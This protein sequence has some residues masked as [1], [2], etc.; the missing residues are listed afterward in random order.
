[1]RS[2]R[3]GATHV[4]ENEDAAS[5]VLLLPA[6]AFLLRL[7]CQHEIVDPVAKRA[8]VASALRRKTPCARCSQ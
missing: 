6:P 3:R 1:M 5:L 4:V 7:G 2:G 8:F